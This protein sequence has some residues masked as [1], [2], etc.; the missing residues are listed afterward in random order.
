MIRKQFRQY[1]IV[2]SAIIFTTIIWWGVASLGI[3][4]DSTTDPATTTESTITTELPTTTEPEVFPL[5]FEYFETNIEQTAKEAIEFTVKVEN[6]KADGE[7]LE[8]YLQQSS[9]D[10][11][12][13]YETTFMVNS[14][15]GEVKIILPDNWWKQVNSEWRLMI[16]DGE[17]EI[18]SDVI[19][20][21]ATRV[22][23]NPS[24]YYQIKDKIVLPE[25]G[26]VKGYKYA[27]WQLKMF[28][29][30]DTMN[31]I[32]MTKKEIIEE[33]IKSAR[34][35]IGEPY[36]YRSSKVGYGFD[37]SGLIMYSLYTVGVSPTPSNVQRHTILEK[38]RLESPH[39]FK[40][41]KMK[42]ISYAEKK[43]GDLVF[44]RNSSGN[45]DSQRN[46]SWK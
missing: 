22:Y 44:Y 29:V 33:M 8:V 19:K 5:K 40:S 41:K 36:K 25:N 37:C 34:S 42:N 20:V 28:K 43:R 9:G 39:L 38:Y 14:E 11:W 7:P 30:P 46:L 15:T 31:T 17:S 27:K 21:T 45:C 26:G 23:Q 10:T 1:T 13:S 2:F 4:A 32:A 12:E 3:F 16:K 24:Q 18:L 35:N 6:V